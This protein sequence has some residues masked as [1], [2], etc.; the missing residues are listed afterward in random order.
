MRVIRLSRNFGQTAALAAGIAHAR[1]EIIVTLDGDL[2]NDP[3]DIPQLI[4]KLKEGYDLVND[5]RVKRQRPFLARRLPYD[6]YDRIHAT[7]AQDRIWLDY[8]CQ[9]DLTKDLNAFHELSRGNNL[10]LGAGSHLI[11]EVPCTSGEG[12][13]SAR[14][15]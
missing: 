11:C 5:W 1:G 10:Q 8:S 12:T 7:S 13:Y 6:Q 4:D 9:T 15:I 3:A 2:Q 14:M